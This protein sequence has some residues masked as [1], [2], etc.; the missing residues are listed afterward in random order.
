MKKFFKKRWHSIPIGL[1]A[2]ILSVC[3]VAGSVFAA[4]TVWE[5]NAKVTVKEAFTIENTT[6]DNGE[7]FTGNVGDYVWN[8][9]LY[10]GQSKSLNVLVS[11]ATPNALPIG[12]TN[13]VL[14][15][16]GKAIWTDKDTVPGDGSEVMT[17]TV[18]VD[19][20]APPG[21]PYSFNLDISRGKLGTVIITGK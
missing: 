13:T 2:G 19:E 18:T 5:G 8:V 15:G 3:L 12:V 7:E 20:D 21:G 6:G 1:L 17:L 4:Y 9:S 14:A 11:N 16:T 10:P